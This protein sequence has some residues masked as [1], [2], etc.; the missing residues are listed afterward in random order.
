MLPLDQTLL[1]YF[2]EALAIE[3]KKNGDVHVA[4]AKML[5]L[6]G[7]IHLERAEVNDFMNCYTEASRIYKRQGQPQETLLVTAGYK[8]YALSKNHPEC[9][10]IT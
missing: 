4:V 9:A 5:N 8:F 6:I 10:V 1:E 3:R 7:N 2:R